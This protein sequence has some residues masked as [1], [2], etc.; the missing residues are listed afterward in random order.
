MVLTNASSRA[1][2]MTQTNNRPQSADFGS[3]YPSV[4]ISAYG[5]RNRRQRGIYNIAFWDAVRPKTN[6]GRTTGRV[7]EGARGSAWNVKGTSTNSILIDNVTFATQR[8]TAATTAYNTATTA[9]TTATNQRYEND[10]VNFPT[11]KLLGNIAITA[12]NTDIGILQSYL[13]NTSYGSIQEAITAITVLQDKTDRQAELDSL[14]TRLSN[15][16]TYTATDY[17]TNVTIEQVVAANEQLQNVAKDADDLKTLVGATNAVTDVSGAN[18]ATILARDRE[19]AY[20]S[21]VNTE[22]STNA[23]KTAA[24]SALQKANAAVY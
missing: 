7:V 17:D 21:A 24:N 12:I 14:K 11:D 15:I 16:A 8:L 10:N 23:E 1:R 3:I 19:A 4:G 22:T 9:K 2:N 5:N 20:T 13:P 6:G 18:N